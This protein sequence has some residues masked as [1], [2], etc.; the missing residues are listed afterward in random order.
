M[1]RSTQYCML[2]QDAAL[3]IF[4]GPPC[5]ASNIELESAFHLYSLQSSESRENHVNG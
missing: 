5:F 2:V 1:G 3:N 4:D